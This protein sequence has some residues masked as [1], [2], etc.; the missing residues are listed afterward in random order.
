[1]GGARSGKAFE[2]L[3]KNLSMT[4]EQISQLL[5]KIKPSEPLRMMPRREP[6]RGI[7]SPKN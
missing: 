5:P 4:D 3:L 2:L 1:M 6:I 7:P